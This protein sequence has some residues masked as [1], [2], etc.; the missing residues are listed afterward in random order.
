MGRASNQ[1]AREQGILILS[2]ST[3]WTNRLT[4]VSWSLAK[5]T[6]SP[7]TQPSHT[8]GRLEPTRWKPAL[9]ERT[10]ECYCATNLA[11]CPCDK[12]GQLQWAVLTCTQLDAK[13]KA[14]FTSV[15]GSKPHPSPTLSSAVQ[16]TDTHKQVPWE[17]QHKASE[18]WIQL[19]EKMV[20]RES[21]GRHRVGKCYPEN[22][23]RKPW[24]EASSTLLALQMKL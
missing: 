15:L 3:N 10:W 23:S 6:P 22:A 21:G 18:S 12:G 9:Q 1:Y 7:K 24:W 11:I 14:F 13:E 2:I 5:A 16:N 19:S 4:D 17:A 8:T 20:G